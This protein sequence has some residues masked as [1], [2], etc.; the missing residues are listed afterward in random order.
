MDT[1]MKKATNFTNNKRNAN[2]KE[3]FCISLLNGQIYDSML[4]RGQRDKFSHILLMEHKV[5]Q[6]FWRANWQYVSK[7][8]KVFINV[9]PDIPTS[10]HL[11]SGNY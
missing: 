7:A 2:E 8:F 1:K 10:R 5:V 6:P 3:S 11:S 9:W 4:R